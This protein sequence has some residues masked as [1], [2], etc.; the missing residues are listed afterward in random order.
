[1]WVIVLLALFVATIASYGMIPTLIYKIRNNMRRKERTDKVLYL[2]FDDGPDR[3]FTPSLLELLNQYDIKASFFVVASFAGRHPDIIANIKENGHCIALHS[4]QHNNP[5][6]QTPTQ[7]KL[8]FEQS[9]KVFRNQKINPC[10]YRP[11][12]LRFNLPSMQQMKNYHLKP[13][14]C[15]VMAED[16]RAHT[17]ADAICKKLLNRS[18]SGDIICL[19]DGRGRNEAPGRMIEALKKTIPCWLSQ[20]YRFLKV[21]EYDE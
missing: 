17:T 12:W 10:G 3:K 9:L 19:H 16:W 1:M 14:L 4:Y 15:N 6:W 13:M 2:T 20:G 11:P 5:F 21:D 18:K 7:I 8:D